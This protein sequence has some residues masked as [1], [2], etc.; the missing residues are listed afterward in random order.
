MKKKKR[1]YEWEIVADAI[2]NGGCF[3][4]TTQ[5]DGYT[6]VHQLI[7]KYI[8]QECN[9]SDLFSL[10][11]TTLDM[12]TRQFDEAVFHINYDVRYDGLHA[13]KCKPVGR[14]NIEF[15]TPDKNYREAERQ[16]ADRQIRNVEKAVKPAVKEIGKT[17]PKLLKVCRKRM[18]HLLE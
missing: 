15:I 11:H 7:A 1:K 3:D 6:R 9:E 4:I 16:N 17:T 2:I 12:I 14:R 8:L 18:I 5:K 10:W 13:Y